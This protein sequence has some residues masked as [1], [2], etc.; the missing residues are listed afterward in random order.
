M[1]VSRINGIEVETQVEQQGVS[2]ARQ[3]QSKGIPREPRL[4]RGMSRTTV[5][6]HPVHGMGCPKGLGRL[7]PS[8][9]DRLGK[10]LQEK[11]T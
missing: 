6:R 1:S 3:A 9:K 11:D 7:L 5:D 4:V 2:T 8:N 10:H